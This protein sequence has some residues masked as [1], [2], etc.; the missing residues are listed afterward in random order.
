LAKQIIGML[1]GSGLEEA[2]ATV[3]WYYH[4]CWNRR[5]FQI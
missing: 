2:T 1:S 5:Q 4:I 3:P